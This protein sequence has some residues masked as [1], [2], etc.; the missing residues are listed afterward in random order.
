[1]IK[2]KGSGR[3]GRRA[4]VGLA[5]LVGACGTVFLSSVGPASAG[6]ALC[7]GTVQPKEKGKPSIDAKY[8]FACTEDVRSFSIVT[9]KKFDFFGT[10][11]IVFYAGQVSQQSAI[12][13]CEGPV[14]GS[15]FGCGV[16]NRN[17]P[18]N[19][20]QTQAAAQCANKVNAH[21][22]ITADVGFTRSPCSYKPG[23]EPLKVW[24]VA[25]YEPFNDQIN[26]TTGATTT[27]SGDYTS[28]PF[29]LKVKGYGRGACAAAAA[30][31]KKGSSGKK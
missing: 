26:P 30:K 22:V 23:E 29:S 11:L 4:V 6:R 1:M 3:R 8:A 14:P 20:G 12:L 18:S 7:K 2:T 10:E 16:N 21:S 15:G 19:C 31:N 24:L 28:E 17:T 9:N 13:Q 25:G 27:N 5:V